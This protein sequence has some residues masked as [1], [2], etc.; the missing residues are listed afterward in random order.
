MGLYCRMSGLELIAQ[1][2]AVVDELLTCPGEGA[3]VEL[4][5]RRRRPGGQTRAFCDQGCEG[6]RIG[7]IGLV[8]LTLRASVARR[9]LRV[10]QEDVVSLGV[11]PVGEFI[12]VG[13]GAFQANPQGT[14]KAVAFKPAA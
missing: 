9:V 5:R 7:W 14:T 6:E 4:F 12:R 13:A 3:Q 10:E 11:K 1:L 8:A 2:L